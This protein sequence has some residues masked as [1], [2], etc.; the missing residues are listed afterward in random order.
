MGDYGWDASYLWGE[1]RSIVHNSHC[2]SRKKTVRLWSADQ[3]L[4]PWMPESRQ[5]LEQY[6][7]IKCVGP[8]PFV[9][10]AS[11][12]RLEFRLR[13]LVGHQADRKDPALQDEVTSTSTRGADHPLLR[14]KVPMH[15]DV[16]ELPN[17]MINV[18]LPYYQAIATEFAWPR[19]KSAGQQQ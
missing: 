8:P 14:R 6:P 5:I 16:P 15:L 2:C 19:H 18:F 12:R 4:P 10:N 7:S 17:V 9:L 11:P 1:G 13:C 3:N